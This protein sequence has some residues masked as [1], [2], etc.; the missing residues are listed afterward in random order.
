MRQPSVCGS[1]RMKGRSAL[2]S[3][4]LRDSVGDSAGVYADKH[5][6]DHRRPHPPWTSSWPGSSPRVS[7]GGRWASWE[8]AAPADSPRP[9]GG[10]SGSLRFQDR[11][12]KEMRLAGVSTLDAANQFLTGYL[13]M[14][15]ALRRRL[16]SPLICIGPV[17]RAASW[18]GA[19]AL[20]PHG[21]CAATGRWRTR[22]A[23]SGANHVRATHVMVEERVD[24]TMRITPTANHW[25]I[26]PSPLAPREWLS[27]PRPKSLGVRSSRPR[28][29]RG[30]NGC[31]R[32][33][34]HM[35][36]R[37]S[38]KPDISTVA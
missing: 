17:R 36:R 1:T 34:T 22:A 30:A 5:T 12:I 29:I 23:R 25:T 15:S 18:T 38:P 3:F 11:V 24:G 8:S 35:R 37:P 31:S 2:D 21:A 9:R 6:T 26:T 14:T 4:R 32:H 27:L 19:C 20:R 28:L 13:P 33:E 7:V 10:W 16:R